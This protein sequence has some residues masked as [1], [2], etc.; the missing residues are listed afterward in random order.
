MGLGTEERNAGG[1]PGV[2][3]DV[4]SETASR[5]FYR[6]WHDLLLGKSWEQIQNDDLARELTI[7]EPQPEEAS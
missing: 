2:T 1:L 3:N 4:F 7:A 5:G 6:R